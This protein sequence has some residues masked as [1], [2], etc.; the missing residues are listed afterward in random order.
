MPLAIQQEQQHLL[1]K[2]L[3]N[4]QVLEGRGGWLQLSTPSS[5][6]RPLFACTTLSGTGGLH[7]TLIDTYVC[8][9]NA[10]E[11]VRHLLRMQHNSKHDGKLANGAR[12][13]VCGLLL[14]STVCTRAPPSPTTAA[15]QLSQVSTA[16]CLAHNGMGFQQNQVCCFGIWA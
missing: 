11:A 16:M 13:C 10:A 2:M 15:L 14:A 6:N 4:S 12:I 1:T 9:C 3:H 7:G 5:T 8:A